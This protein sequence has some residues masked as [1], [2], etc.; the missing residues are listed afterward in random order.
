MKAGEEPRQQQQA[1]MSTEQIVWGKDRCWPIF[2]KRF[3]RPL[4]CRRF[5]TWHTWEEKIF[6]YLDT[7]ETSNHV[8]CILL[9]ASPLHRW[10]AISGKNIHKWC[11]HRQSLLLAQGTFVQFFPLSTRYKLAKCYKVPVE[12]AHDNL[13]IN[14]DVVIS[15]LKNHCLLLVKLWDL[16]HENDNDVLM[17][18]LTFAKSNC[19]P[20]H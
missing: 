7:F 11:R 1:V 4:L 14:K 12:F 13:Q 15:T 16:C 17:R 19:I 3:D 18:A 20:F 2:Q 9:P 8:M 5:V 6:C 10:L